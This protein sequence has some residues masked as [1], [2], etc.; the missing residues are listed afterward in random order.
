MK[1]AQSA[2]PSP[3]SM[4]TIWLRYFEC[5]SKRNETQPW[6]TFLPR[7]R[8]SHRLPPRQSNPML[9]LTSPSLRS[10]LAAE[11]SEAKPP[12]ARGQRE[13][14]SQF[15]AHGANAQG[16]HDLEMM[17]GNVSRA[18]LKLASVAST[19]ISSGTSAHGVVAP[20]GP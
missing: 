15:T 14:G 1:Y 17:S 16:T 13:V 9:Q 8:K 11:C 6:L 7:R 3:A 18:W 19:S 10:G 20:W 2:I 4:T 12:S 5:F